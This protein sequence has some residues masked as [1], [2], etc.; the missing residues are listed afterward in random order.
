MNNRHNKK[1]TKYM[2][3]CKTNYLLLKINNKMKIKE[4]VDLRKRNKKIM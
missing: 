4:K 3:I 2:Q 1:N